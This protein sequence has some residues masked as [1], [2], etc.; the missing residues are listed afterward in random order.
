M[1]NFFLDTA[2]K[3][4]TREANSYKN[5]KKKIQNKMTKQTIFGSTMSL[6]ERNLSPRLLM[7]NED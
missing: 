7:K 3:Y 4:G 1:H 2:S 5:Y 6:E